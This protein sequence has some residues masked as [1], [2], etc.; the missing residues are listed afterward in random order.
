MFKSAVMP[1]VITGASLGMLGYAFLRRANAKRGGRSVLAE[2]SQSATQASA[3]A[4]YEPTPESLEF[5]FVGEAAAPPLTG[6]D[7][8]DHIQELADDD[9]DREWLA[10]RT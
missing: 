10:R 5:D 1:I 4:P 2:V 6:P 9:I 8:A 7:Y 3:P